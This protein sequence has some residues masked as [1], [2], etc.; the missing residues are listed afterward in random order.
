MKKRILLAAGG[1]IVLLV[2]LGVLLVLNLDRVVKAGVEKGGT[3]ILGVPTKLDSASVSLLGGT[4]DLNGLTLGSPEGFDA[5][6]ML[7]LGHAHVSVD[8]GSL[9]SKEMVVHEVVIDGAEVTLEFS[10]TK[11]NWGALMK[12]LESEPAEEEQKR[13]SERKLRISR[14]VFSNGSVNVRGIPLTSSATL[15]LPDLEITEF[16]TGEGTASTVVGVLAGVVRQLYC[17][18]LGAAKGLI[19]AEQMQEIA[20]ELKSLAGEA[21]GALKEASSAVEGL[22]KGAAGAAGGL[23]RGVLGGDEKDDKKGE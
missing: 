6:E 15:G 12:H 13:K 11:T 2:V 10:G 7:R 22:G 23:L 16:G 20:G 14:I 3:L 21:G 17:S 19:P 1:L 18:V 5:P 9:R 8:L 4:V